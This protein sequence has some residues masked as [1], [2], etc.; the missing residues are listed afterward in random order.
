MTSLADRASSARAA[1]RA[2]ASTSGELRNAVLRSAADALR[3]TAGEILAANG[4]DV[5]R[6]EGLTEA[7]LARLHLDAAKVEDM[8][9]GLESLAG[10]PDPLGRVDLHR[11]LDEGLVLTRVSVPIG[12]VGVVFESRPDA[13][14]QIGGLAIKSG[15]AVLLKG[16][17]EALGSVR[18]LVAALRGALWAH[19][20]SLDAVQQLED[21]ADVDEM[22][23]LSGAIDLIVPRGSNELVRSIQA[24][25]RIPVLGHADGICHVYVDAAADPDRAVRIVHDAKLQYPA[26]CNAAETLLVHA[27]ASYLLPS[28]AA[29]LARSGVEL[30]GDDTARG[31]APM[32]A[33]SEAD[34]GTEYGAAVLAVRVVSDLDAALAHIAAY[35]SGHTEVIVTEDPAA[36]D[37]FLREVDAAG[38]YH[39]ASSRFADGYRYG[40][41]AEV[42]ISTGR[43]HARGPVGLEGLVTT[44][45]LLRGSGQVVA[46]YAGPEARGFTHRDLPTD[47]A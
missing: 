7:S 11:E 27:D 3:H 13:A 23:T 17:R 14:V 25:T 44:K 1:S 28:I 29:D 12:V 47:S 24:R 5:A 46:D 40:F 26:A 43:I 18:V 4:D 10:L 19:G 16:G 6:A 32:A 31:L 35:G 33:A 45:Y 42:G 36:A 8:A 22:L 34:W 15:N 41:G 38:V 39:N 9:R 2:L 20:L 21:R 37:R 30:R